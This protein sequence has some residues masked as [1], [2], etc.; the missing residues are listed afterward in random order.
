MHN[1]NMNICVHFIISW[2]ES[3]GPNG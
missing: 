2:S 3:A 1:Y